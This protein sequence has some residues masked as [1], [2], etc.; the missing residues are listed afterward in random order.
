MFRNQPMSKVLPILMPTFN[1]VEI[2]CLALMKGEKYVNIAA[3]IFLGYECPDAI[4]NGSNAWRQQVR[5]DLLEKEKLK[6]FVDVYPIANIKTII[7]SLEQGFLIV[8]DGAIKVPLKPETSKILNMPIYE[9]SPS[10]TSTGFPWLAVCGNINESIIG[11][12]SNE[13]L[14]PSRLGVGD[15]RDLGPMFLNADLITS[16]NE[17]MIFAP[18]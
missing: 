9:N 17:L 14:R 11:R 18:F 16:A 8:N 2:R 10:R 6:L 12:L 5:P 4:K 3:T 13:N 7:D 15:L 1:S